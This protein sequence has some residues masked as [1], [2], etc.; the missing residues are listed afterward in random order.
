MV[1]ADEMVFAGDDTRED[2]VRTRWRLFYDD[3]RQRPY[4]YDSVAKTSQWDRPEDFDGDE[5]DADSRERERDV[6]SRES[7][8]D[9]EMEMGEMFDMGEDDHGSIEVKSETEMEPEP[10][11]EPEP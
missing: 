6:S 1:D 10:E 7:R 4:Y 11:H 8:E 3:V 2:G 9:A 5:D